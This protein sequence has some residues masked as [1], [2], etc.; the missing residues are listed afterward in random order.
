MAGGHLT[1]APPDPLSLAVGWVLEGGTK[2]VVRRIS[3]R[4]FGEAEE[5]RVLVR[6]LHNASTDRARF[7]TVSG[8]LPGVGY[9]VC[10]S[11]ISGDMASMDRPME[12]G[13]CREVLTLA[14][15]FPVEEVTAAAAVSGSTTA[16]MVALLCCCCFPCRRKGKGKNGL[17]VNENEKGKSEA[18]ARDKLFHQ[19]Y[20]AETAGC[21]SG[22][23]LP[24]VRPDGSS[25]SPGAADSRDSSSP[26]EESVYSQIR[27]PPAGHTCPH[28]VEVEKNLEDAQEDG[29]ESRRKGRKPASG[30]LTVRS[31]HSLSSKYSDRR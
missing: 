20:I 19:R 16:V 10:F 17:D 22:L 24:C 7:Y 1:V 2:P 5:E 29:E 18:D 15:T 28:V 6:D 13:E 4:K 11:T 12:T 21:S 9:T 30:G 25:S 23:W 31:A 26:G 14:S 8:L 3:V 27:P